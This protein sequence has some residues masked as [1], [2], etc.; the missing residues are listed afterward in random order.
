M[1]YSYVRIVTEWRSAWLGRPRF[2][3]DEFHERLQQDEL[4]PPLTLTG[5]VKKPDDGGRSFLFLD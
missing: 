2:S 4:A 3:P 1:V 5:M